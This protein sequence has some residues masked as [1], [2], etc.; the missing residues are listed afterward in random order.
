[1]GLSKGVVT[2]YVGLAVV[3]SLDWPTV[4]ALDE[5]TLERR[6][7]ASPRPSDNYAL[8]DFARM[9][10]ELGRKGM[11]LTLLWEEYCAKVSDEFNPDAPVKPWRY[12]PY[13]ENYRQFAKRLKRSMR[14]VHRV[15]EKLFLDYAG[16]TIALLVN[17]HTSSTPFRRS[18][19]F[20]GRL[21]Q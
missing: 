4:A 10:Q 13:C 9:H 6:L 15:G 14:Q 1:M 8:A 19:G 21:C 2:K 7:L 17:S 18:F 16:P 12:F 5:A 20:S 11:T 3:A